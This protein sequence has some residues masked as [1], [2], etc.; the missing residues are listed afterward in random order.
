ME[1]S[2]P[3]EPESGPRPSIALGRPDSRHRLPRP[4]VG[5]PAYEAAGGAVALDLFHDEDGNG[6]YCSDAALLDRLARV[7]AII[8]K[9]IF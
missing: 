4:V 9:P 1:Q 2:P 3:V 6:T 8:E 7:L 5:L